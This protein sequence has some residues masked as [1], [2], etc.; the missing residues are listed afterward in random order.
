MRGQ[1]KG[2]G[3]AAGSGGEP[4]GRALTA[5]RRSLPKAAAILCGRERGRRDREGGR[6][7]V[8]AP[9][10]EEEA[11]PW[12]LYSPGGVFEAGQS[13]GKGEEGR[14]RLPALAGGV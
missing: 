13:A 5:L 2:E 8:P 3:E 10:Q 12:R 6:R 4:G 14:A 9:R 11:S 7:A 1:E